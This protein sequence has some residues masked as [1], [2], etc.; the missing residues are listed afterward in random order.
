[1]KKVKEGYKMTELGEIPEDW[2]VVMI[3]TVCES[4][5]Y[6]GKTPTKTNHGIFLVTAKNIGKGYI[7]YVVS[8]EFVSKEDYHSVMSRGLPKKGDVLFTT[9]APLG[10][11]ANVDN[12]NIALAQRIIKFRGKS[13]IVDNYY[14]KHYMLGD[15]FQNSIIREATVISSSCLL[16]AF[17][18]AHSISF[19]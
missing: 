6:R 12:E 11:V 2:E 14:L 8:Q 17:L 1:M 19:S 16:I 7:D 13:G 4:V 18:T 10:Y 5:D 3:E 9:E 15:K